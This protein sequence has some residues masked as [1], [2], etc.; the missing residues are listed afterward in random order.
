M[1]FQ[2]FYIAGSLAFNSWAIVSLAH[3]LIFFFKVEAE[4]IAQSTKWL[5][6]WAHR[7]DFS[8]PEM[9]VLKS[10]C[11]GGVVCHSSA[12]GGGSGPRLSGQPVSLRMVEP[13]VNERPCLKGGQCLRSDGQG[14]PLASTHTWACLFSSPSLHTHMNTHVD[15]HT[16][17]I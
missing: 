12:G 4:E 7:P 11:S 2:V 3:N 6:L 16:C 15:T 10:R 9:C 17:E 8:P 13:Q 5:L 1:Q 14:C